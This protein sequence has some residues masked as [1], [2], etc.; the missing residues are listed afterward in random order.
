MLAVNK[1]QVNAAHPG[2]GADILKWWTLMATDVITQLSFGE[3]F[4]MLAIFLYRRAAAHPDWGCAARRSSSR[5]LPASIL[6]FR[7]RTEDGHCR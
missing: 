6:A 2:K 5:A 1:I 3:S 7:R 4:E